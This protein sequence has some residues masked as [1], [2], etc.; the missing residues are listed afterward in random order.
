MVSPGL[1]PSSWLLTSHLKPCPRRDPQVEAHLSRTH[2]CDS[3]HSFLISSSSSHLPEPLS[4]L[5]PPSSLSELT[6]CYWDITGCLGYCRGDVWLFPLPQP[7]AP[8][9]RH[10]AWYL[11]HFWQ[12]KWLPSQPL[13]SGF[14]AHHLHVINSVRCGSGGSLSEKSA[15][16]TV[17]YQNTGTEEIKVNGGHVQPDVFPLCWSLHHHLNVWRPEWN[18]NIKV[19]AWTASNFVMARHDQ[20]ATIVTVTRIQDCLLELQNLHHVGFY[21][22]NSCDIFTNNCSTPE[23]KD[24]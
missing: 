2:L 17:H 7:T 22:A 9:S 15:V 10:E 1:L 24:L 16:A 12:E 19:F 21:W 8:R 5:P 13:L 6:S 14:A 3:R 20:S 18:V 11:N 4:F 23:C